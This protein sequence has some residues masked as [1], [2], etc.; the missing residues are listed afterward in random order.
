MKAI[1]IA[2]PPRIGNNTFPIKQALNILPE[3]GIEKRS[4]ILPSPCPM[5]CKK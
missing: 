2:G 5:S 4:V 3:N 1:G